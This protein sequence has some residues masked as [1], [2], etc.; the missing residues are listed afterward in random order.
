MICRFSA[1]FSGAVLIRNSDSELIVIVTPRLVKPL[2]MAKQTM[3]TDQF[4]DPDDFEFYLLGITEG[5][6]E[7]RSSGGP[8]QPAEPGRRQT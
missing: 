3:P 6:G 4:V 7:P 1:L 8:T 2:D 5:R